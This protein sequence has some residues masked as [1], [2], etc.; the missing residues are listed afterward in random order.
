MTAAYLS[1]R[2]QFGRPLG[3][4]QA[5]QQRVADAYIDVEAMRWTMWQ[6]SWLIDEGVPASDEVAIAKYWA[7]EGGH[8]VLAAAQ[9]LHGGIGVDI[10]YPLHRYTLG[11]K[12][13]EL[14]L[15]GSSRHLAR[16]GASMAAKGGR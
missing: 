1:E 14:T 4:F 8:R 6:A 5:V 9:H 11:A 2:E 13:L 7:A 3:K 16:L 10:E 12:H 15:G